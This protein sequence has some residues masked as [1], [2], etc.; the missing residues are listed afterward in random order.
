[1]TKVARSR[2]EKQFAATQKKQKAALNEREKLEKQR[3][4]HRLHLRGLRFAKEAADKQVAA[5]EAAEKAKTA[6]A[7]KAA[8][9]EADKEAK[10]AARQAA[11]A[12]AAE[13]AAG[14]PAPVD[15][16]GDTAPYPQAHRRAS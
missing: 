16:N 4:E 5:V 8:K 11:K 12:A 1:M 6:A 2:A 10:K 7:G 9:K 13:A 3:A 14:D 15:D